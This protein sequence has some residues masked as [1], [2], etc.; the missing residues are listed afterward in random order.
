MNGGM[1]GMVFALGV[2]IG[3]TF[4]DAVAI[5]GEG[6]VFTGKSDTTPD[7]PSDGVIDALG[8]LAGHVDMSLPDLLG[9]TIF[10]GHGTTVGTNSLINKRGAKVGLVVTKGFEDTPFIQRSVG[11]IA[12]LSEIQ[13]KNQVVL[14]QPEFLLP[15]SAVRG[16]AERIDCFG[17]VVVPL[18]RDEARRAAES[19]IGA[20]AEAIAVCFLWSFA[21]DQHEHEVKE[22]ISAI[23]PGVMVSI[24]S[25]LIPKM[26]ENARL[27]STVINCFVGK[28]VVHYL[29]RLEQRLADLGLAT[30]VNVMQVFGGL[31]DMNNSQPICTIDSG[32]VGGVIAAKFL[33]EEMNLPNLVTTDVGGT[34]FDVSVIHGGQEQMAKEY[35]GA[36]GV[37][38]RY[39]VSIPRVDIKCIGA[40]GGT[41]ARYNPISRT[42]KLGPDSA[43]AD[44]GPVFYDAGGT[45]PT[46][47]DAWVT[48]GLINPDNFLGGRRQVYS[49][50][51]VAA[52]ETK[53][54]RPAEMSTQEAASAV[55]ELA[56]NTMADAIR[57]Q[58][59]ERGY[60]PLD[61][62]ILAFGGAGWLHATSYGRIMGIERIILARNASVFSAL[63]IALADIVHKHAQSAVIIEPIG[64]DALMEPIDTIRRKLEGEMHSYGDF[65]GDVSFSFGVDMRYR[66]QIHELTIALSDDD[67]DSPDINETL[68]HRF[69]KRYEEVYGKGSA[70]ERGGVEI[71]AVIGQSLGQTVKPSMRSSFEPAPES[72]REMSPTAY[73]EVFL[74]HEFHQVGI[75][76]S[77]LTSPGARIIGPAI[78]E[79]PVT[80]GLVLPGQTAVV[81][82]LLNIHVFEG[83][84]TDV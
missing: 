74:D 30:P 41:I 35:F 57:E 68:K 16:V 20:G 73:R 75:I 21:N 46:L 61:F 58:L 78:I 79:D 4:T 27:N 9:Q 66:G 25:E 44:P 65:I 49:A 64:R 51:S 15:K 1:T 70:Y 13:I 8:N 60:D 29:A 53:L 59:A 12:G 23:D 54:A 26:R 22:I 38:D 52:I 63:G 67:F 62:S 3:G 39:E 2:D 18:D 56:N 42:I 80:T 83:G 14:R 71:I 55:V 24:S 40:G 37:M 19:L 7:D 45:E 43:G 50:K 72:G 76:E 34:S 31:T 81:D 32:P 36:T 17:Q 82:N 11:R 33:A 84:R 47:A 77:S 69:S 5:S 48:L 10:F 28:R 6:A